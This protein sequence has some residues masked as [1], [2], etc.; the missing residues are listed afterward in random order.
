MSVRWQSV[1]RVCQALVQG[2]PRAPRDRSKACAPRADT[3]TPADLAPR[4]SEEP[5]PAAK[6]VEH[7]PSET[8]NPSTQGPPPTENTMQ[9]ATTDVFPASA[10]A[11]RVPAPATPPTTSMAASAP[12]TMLIR[13]LTP[14]PG[15]RRP[16]DASPGRPAA[17]DTHQGS[18]EDRKGA[19]SIGS[20]TTFS[21]LCIPAE[22]GKKAIAP[23]R[24][25]PT[26]AL[27]VRSTPT[28]VASIRPDTVETAALCTTEPA[29]HVNVLVRCT[30]D[31]LGAFG[32]ALTITQDRRANETLDIVLTA[33]HEQMALVIEGLAESRRDYGAALERAVTRIT[34]EAAPESLINIGEVFQH[35][36]E[37]ITGALRRGEHLQGRVLEALRDIG[38]QLGELKQQIAA[39][40]PFPQGPVARPVEPPVDKP[41][42]SLVATGTSN[43]RDSPLNRLDDDDD[44]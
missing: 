9:S 31:L 14:P 7:R 15:L 3:T 19:T 2:A 23:P 27:V 24:V 32:E 13:P 17:P 11:E 38:L 28:Q 8:A 41:A 5:P 4:K 6:P 34:Q 16:P 33:Q 10:A 44:T 25:T 43:P 26:T 29:T 30:Q 18:Q 12:P 20:G 1:R 22:D 39:M 42:L 36:A 35:S 21:S 37:Q 40:A